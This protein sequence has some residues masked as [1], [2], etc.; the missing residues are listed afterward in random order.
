MTFYQIHP[1]KEGSS[2]E[3]TKETILPERELPYSVERGIVPPL[4][5]Y[6]IVFFRPLCLNHVIV[7]ACTL[8]KRQLR[9]ALSVLLTITIVN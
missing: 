5:Q 4:V 6:T 2:Q 8:Y 1:Y 7:P 9:S 3:D